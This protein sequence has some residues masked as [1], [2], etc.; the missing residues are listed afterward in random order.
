MAPMGVER[1][2]FPPSGPSQTA[3]P[4]QGYHPR[5]PP[6]VRDMMAGTPPVPAFFAP[7]R[8]CVA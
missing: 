2:E 4:P 6:G 7:V 5:V 1:A 3:L 8:Y